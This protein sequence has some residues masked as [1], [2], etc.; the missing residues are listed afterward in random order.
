VGGN[1]NYA[2][3]GKVKAAPARFSQAALKLLF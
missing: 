2:T 3:F 1:I